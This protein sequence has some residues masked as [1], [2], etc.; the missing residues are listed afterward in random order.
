MQ[1]NIRNIDK[2]S[3]VIF[4]LILAVA[5]F[6]FLWVMQGFSTKRY[7]DQV[8]TEINNYKDKLEVSEKKI[9]QYYQTMLDAQLEKY[10]LELINDSLKKVEAKRVETIK[11][12]KYERSKLQKRYNN[13]T[14][15]NFDT[16]TLDSL[17]KLL[18]N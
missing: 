10:Q 17:D 6:A 5:L 12:L 11:K 2:K 18:P 16:I 8:E 14:H 7:K 15:P 4:V 9:K 1:I 3:I 13:V